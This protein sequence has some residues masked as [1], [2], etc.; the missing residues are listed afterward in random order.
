L[1]GRQIA[2]VA[3]AS[4]F[5]MIGCCWLLYV[6]ESNSW[7]DLMLVMETEAPRLVLLDRKKKESSTRWVDDISHLRVE[8][9]FADFEALIGLD[10]VEKF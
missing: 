8:E 3:A 5:E 1:G 7:V 9:C 4:D 6:S 2:T 10:V